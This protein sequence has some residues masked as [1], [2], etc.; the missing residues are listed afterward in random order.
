MP[1]VSPFRTAKLTPCT[2]WTAGLERPS[3]VRP[4]PKDRSTSWACSIASPASAMGHGLAPRMQGE[5]AANLPPL[6]QALQRNFAA[7]AGVPG[8]GAAR[9]KGAAGRTCTGGRRTSVDRVQL[10]VALPQNGHAVDQLAGIGMCGCG[11]H[12]SGPSRLDDLPG[13]H[14]GNPIG[15]GGDDTE[16]S[17]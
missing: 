6:L 3:S 13:I 1:R 7:S 15:E 12:V 16:R 11:Q 14:D 5:E 4:P 9:G 8:K 17:E 10:A 2:A